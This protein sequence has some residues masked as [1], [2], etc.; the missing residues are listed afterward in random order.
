MIQTAHVG[1][2]ISGQEGVQAVNSSDYAIAQFRFLKP[3]LLVHGRQNYKRIAKVILY[4][5]YK[6][7]ALV[8]VL[9]LF[10]FWNGFSGT[11]LFESFVMAGWNFFLAMPIIVIGVSD[12]DVRPPLLRCERMRGGGKRGGAHSASACVR[13]QV[14][15]YLS[16]KNPA[17]YVSGPWRLDLNV[18]RFLIWIINAIGHAMITYFLPIQTMLQSW[19]SN[20]EMDGLYVQG[21]TI[22]SCLL[23]TMNYKVALETRCVL[24]P[25]PPVRTGLPPADCVCTACFHAQVLE[26]LE[27]LF[28]LGQHCPLHA[29]PGHLQRV[30]AWHTAVLLV[31]VRDVLAPYVLAPARVGSLRLHHLRP[32]H[33]AVRAPPR[34]PTT[35]PLATHAPGRLRLLHHAVSSDPSARSRVV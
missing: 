23:M 13:M 29:V 30:G 26:L 31:R 8:I 18:W 10:N 17:L 15:P 2:G 4:S 21:T 11:T 1:V 22:Y 3:L 5:F 25:P 6:N 28:L 34:A 33:D 20:G 12:Y 24:S 16:M 7:I 14:I 32:R 19:S 9:F 27:P 35:L